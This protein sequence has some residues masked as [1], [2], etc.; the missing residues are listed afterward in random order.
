[1]STGEIQP[2][3]LEPGEYLLH[4]DHGLVQFV[5][6]D[7][8]D[9]GG[10]ARDYV[11]LQLADGKIFLPVEQME[12]LRRD[13]ERTEQA[14]L[15]T[16]RG[17]RPIRA[18]NTSRGGDPL[19][20]AVEFLHQWGVYEPASLVKR[21][22]YE[23]FNL[24]AADLKG[25]ENDWESVLRVGDLFVSTGFS[26]MP[27]QSVRALRQLGVDDRDEIVSGI[28]RMLQGS[29]TATNVGRGVAAREFVGATETHWVDWPEPSDDEEIGDHIWLVRHLQSQ[30][31][32]VQ[33]V[34]D[35]RKFVDQELGPAA[36]SNPDGNSPLLERVSVGVVGV[37]GAEID[38]GAIER[39]RNTNGGGWS[40]FGRLD[41]DRLWIQ[42][43]SRGD[44]LQVRLTN[45]TSEMLGVE[46]YGVVSATGAQLGT[47][48]V[49]REGAAGSV[50]IDWMHDGLEDWTPGE[51]AAILEFRVRPDRTVRM[52][53][54][55]ATARN[56][57]PRFVD[58]CVLLGGTWG[59]LVE[60]DQAVVG[61][62]SVSLP[63]GI[64]G[65]GD[66]PVGEM[67]TVPV[68]EPSVGQIRI[69]REP[70]SFRLERLGEARPDLPIGGFAQIRLQGGSCRIEVAEP[71]EDT[72]EKL[73]RSLGIFETPHRIWGT[74][75]HHLACGEEVNDRQQVKIALAD[76]LRFD[77]VAL[78]S[79]ASN[80]TPTGDGL[81]DP[82]HLEVTNGFLSQNRDGTHF[83]TD[84]GT[85]DG[86]FGFQWV[87]NTKYL[88]S[89]DPDWAKKTLTCI[90]AWSVSTVDG[91][92]VIE[93]QD[94]L[95]V[96]P[97]LSDGLRDLMDVLES[98]SSF[99]APFPPPEIGRCF[100]ANNLDYLLV[101]GEAN[102]LMEKIEISE[103]GWW[104]TGRSGGPYGPAPITAL[105]GG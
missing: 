96:T 70:H 71:T 62:A 56:E 34:K 41:R 83:H 39:I 8:R 28:R 88:L 97:R 85:G 18:A 43:K 74:I 35:L 63:L 67:I 55:S 82:D 33:K 6:R 60:I 59:C 13:V 42:A 75:G 89:Q 49:S 14:E 50:S 84:G 37:R 61:G 48:T 2:E 58:G 79:I 53:T 46:P 38:I 5:D 31:G 23:G 77:L 47:L 94:G 16:M 25:L 68:E 66:L 92:I 21:V 57:L 11:V 27:A 69:I 64:D 93:R 86:L 9:V 44:Q 80:I 81:V 40:L 32:G 10:I 52:F 3:T 90:R 73:L 105:R 15:G 12:R 87:K 24:V 100:P 1:M 76:R 103:T 19:Q 98:L 104:G 78:A 95:W 30:P 29:S 91:P 7:T 17:G 22:N 4:E 102:R 99:A 72:T 45:D 54:G 101:L 51:H 20:S 65:T 36:M 26:S